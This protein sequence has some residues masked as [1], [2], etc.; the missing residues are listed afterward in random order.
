MKLIIFISAVFCTNLN[1]K[2]L[3][4]TVAVV[5]DQPIL[6]SQVKRMSQNI[7]ARRN[8]SPQIYSNS[9]YSLKDLIKIKI[10]GTLI[11]EKLTEVGYII[12]DEQVEAQIQATENRLGLNREALLNFLRSNNFSFDEY[13]ELIRS[14]IEHN[15]FISRIIQPLLSISEQDVKYH[16]YKKFSKKKRLNFKYELVDFY[17]SEKQI[18]KAQVGRLSSI[19]T[20]FQRT[21]IL[22]KE[23]SSIMT[24]DLGELSESDLNTSLRNVIGTAEEGTFSRPIK[25]RGDYHVFFVKKKD[26]VESDDFLRL[27]GQIRAEIFQKLIKS[28]SASWFKS[29]AEKHYIKYF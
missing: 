26:L 16:Y 7:D 12:S 3:D 6:L 25:I 24:N 2:L 14:S 28:V 29:Q 9:K 15:L 17:I 20:Q 21:G 22:P 4:K 13:F 23:F 1:A 18:T 27:K 5:N 10:Q 11:K 19:L 8:I